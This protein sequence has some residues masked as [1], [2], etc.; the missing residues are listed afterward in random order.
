[1][2]SDEKLTILRNAGQRPL[3]RRLEALVNAGTITVKDAQ[4]TYR[5]VFGGKVIA[6][7]DHQ[8]KRAVL[9]SGKTRIVSVLDRAP[10][11]RGSIARILG[12]CFLCA[13]L[14]TLITLALRIHVPFPPF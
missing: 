12:A 4:K 6:I 3:L 8:A 7:K 9:G 11:T 1:M 2:P 14:S 10:P 5:D 13:F